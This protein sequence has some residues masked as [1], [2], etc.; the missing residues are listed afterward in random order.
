MYLSLQIIIQTSNEL[1][2][3]KLNNLPKTVYLIKQE[4]N[5]LQTKADDL[6][7]TNDQ[8]HQSYHNFLTIID[9]IK[10]NTSL[11]EQKLRSVGIN[12]ADLATNH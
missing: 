7:I 11:F 1:V 6:I 2:V 10:E 9:E 5:K 12:I 3:H 4:I 8:L